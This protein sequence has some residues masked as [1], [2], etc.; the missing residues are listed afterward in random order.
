MS[1]V[2]L[3]ATCRARVSN[4]KITK[5]TEK[6]FILGQVAL[7]MMGNGKMIKDTEKGFIL[8]QMA[9]NMMGNKKMVKDTVWAN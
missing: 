4:T 7:N 8:G 3:K 9:V 1:A 5:S 6:G 2:F